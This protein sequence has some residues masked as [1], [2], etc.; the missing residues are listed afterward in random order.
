MTDTAQTTA[1]KKFPDYRGLLPLIFGLAI[2]RAGSIVANCDSYRYT[3][4]S[5]ITDSSNLIALSVLV[6]PILALT[7]RNIKMQ[8][9]ALLGIM[10]ASIALQSLTLFGLALLNLSDTSSQ[11]LYL[12][13]SAIHIIGSTGAMFFWMRQ[14]LGCNTGIAVI[15]AFAAMLVSEPLVLVSTYL[16]E[17]QAFILAGFGMLLQFLCLWAS[18]RSPLAAS[19]RIMQSIK[20]FT[21]E[22]QVINRKSILAAVFVACALTSLCLGFLRGYPDGQ[23]IPFTDMTRLAQTLLTMGVEAVIVIIALRSHFWTLIAIIWGSLQG[24]IALT[25]VSFAVFPEMLDVGAIFAT[26]SNALMTAFMVYLYA[27]LMNCFDK[28]DPYVY[29][30]PIRVTWLFSRAFSRSFLLSLPFILNNGILI[31]SLVGFILLVTTQIVFLVF[32]NRLQYEGSRA[33]MDVANEGDM[34]DRSEKSTATALNTALPSAT[35]RLSIRRGA[36]KIGERFLLSEREID[37]LILFAMGHKQERVAEELYISP[38]TVHA[39]IKRIYKKTGFHS[40]QNILDYIKQY[41]EPDK[42]I[43]EQK[44]TSPNASSKQNAE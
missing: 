10:F 44:R 12:V 33:W 18:R 19:L 27:L 15:V 32:F 34:L 26:T 39:H 8:D 29:A 25:L 40:R 14:T 35:S 23:S 21:F 36:R 22:R 41:V 20:G 13:L 1:S 16:S 5:L 31:T 6:I 11:F 24:L 38:G 9:K 7:L 28:L 30:F 3:D 2:M 37:V 42:G 17:V 4:V 43:T